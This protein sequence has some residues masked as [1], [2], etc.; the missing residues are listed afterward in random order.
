MV[1][2]STAGECKGLLK[3]AVRDNNPV[4]FFEHKMLYTTKFNDVPEA[5][6]DVCIPVSYTHLDVYKRQVWVVN[7]GIFYFLEVILSTFIG[8]YF[9]GDGL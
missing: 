2:P 6:E 7:Q 4:M 5:D 8:D 9:D 1:L 3:T